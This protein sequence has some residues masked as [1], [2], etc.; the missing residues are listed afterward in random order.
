[1]FQYRIIICNKQTFPNFQNTHLLPYQ[2]HFTEIA[3]YVKL[4]ASITKH[5][6]IIH[7]Q[8]VRSP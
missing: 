1:M 7:Y 6:I 8:P 5:K 2:I 4:R 3:G